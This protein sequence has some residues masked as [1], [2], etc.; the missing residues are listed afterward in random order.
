MTFGQTRGR[1][2]CF[3]RP[4]HFDTEVLSE[5]GGM[6]IEC[7]GNDHDEITI[8]DERDRETAFGFDRVF[9]TSASNAQVFEEVGRP[10]CTSVLCGYNGT[11]MAY[12]QT[13]SGKTHSLASGDGLMNS[14]LGHLFRTIDEDDAAE[15]YRVSLSYVQVYNEKCFDLLHPSST[16]RALP[17]RESKEGGVYLEGVSE[18]RV[19]SLPETLDLLAVGRKRLHFAETKMNRHSSRSHAC[20]LI[21]VERTV[22]RGAVTATGAAAADGLITDDDQESAD[23]PIGEID[24][25][26]DEADERAA[27]KLALSQA[28]DATAGGEVAVSA[29]LTLVDLAGSERIKRTGASGATLAEAQ[30]INLSL[31]ELGNV[32]QALSESSEPSATTALAAGSGTAARHIPFRNSTLTRLLQESLGGNCR[33]SLLVCVSPALADASETKGSLQ[34]GARAMRVR[35]DAVINCQANYEE[36]AQQLA[37]QLEDKEHVWKR[38]HE[39]LELQLAEALA[40]VD[41]LKV[42][43]ERALAVQEEQSA[44]KLHSAVAAERRGSMAHEAALAVELRAVEKQLAGGLSRLGAAEREVSKLQAEAAGAATRRAVEAEAAAEQRR[45]DEATTTR[46]EATAEAARAEL[47]VAV[48]ALA[49]ADADRAAEEV[50]LIAQKEAAVAEKQSAVAEKESA[51]AEKEAAV[52]AMLLSEGEQQVMAAAVVQKAVVE[53][54]RWDEEHNSQLAAVRLA[55]AAVAMGVAAAESAD[56]AVASKVGVESLCVALSEAEVDLEGHM[57]AAREGKA[58]LEAEQQARERAQ[59]AID[60]LVAR[61]KLLQTELD[62]LRAASKGAAVAALVARFAV[63]GLSSLAETTAVGTPQCSPARTKLKPPERLFQVPS[64]AVGCQAEL[65]DEDAPT[66]PELKWQTKR[67]SWASRLCGRSQ[68]VS[69]GE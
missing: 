22:G 53:E 45:D 27:A 1:I 6:A 32:I 28:L 35:Q 44:H 13:G 21:K 4:R 9:S 67:R 42:A 24:A 46:A 18:S 37:R 55:A 48:A 34:F 54:Q 56:A 10:L 68:R 40:C 60:E 39:R 63:A 31:L 15:L 14:M 38:K 57:S 16:D 65:L 43:H 52:A 69:P 64:V 11:L 3:V 62:T 50:A 36:V 5:R 59:S 47:V 2:K 23:V 17:L 49:A 7:G 26:A 29:R 58:A 25:A 51:V 12:G 20:C 19:A 66:T 41:A 33:T 8:K 30:K 61:T